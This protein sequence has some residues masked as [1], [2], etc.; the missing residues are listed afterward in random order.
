MER[1]QGL[2][3]TVA[4]QGATIASHESVF[5]V[6]VNEYG[7]FRPITDETVR[8]QIKM[9]IDKSCSPST[10][11]VTAS[12]AERMRQQQEA[13][14]VQ[15]DN[16]IAEQK[17]LLAQKDVELSRANAELGRAQAMVKR[18]QEERE[19][20]ETK[21]RSQLK[22]DRCGTSKSLLAQAEQSHKACYSKSL[23]TDAHRS[24]KRSF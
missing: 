2:E 5:D 8:P 16:V 18:I 11:V 19:A 7:M 21:L 23:P 24:K 12:D 3:S 10:A 13:L 6:L 17:Q 9:L 4:S 20:I 22:R 15:K 1:V 14:L